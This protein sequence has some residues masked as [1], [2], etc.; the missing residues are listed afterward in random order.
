MAELENTF[1]WSYSAASDFEV[2]RRR[3]YWSKYGKWGG[4]SPQASPEQRKAYQLDKMDNLYS[5]LG[6]AVDLNPFTVIVAILIG[7][8]LLGL[9]GVVIAIPTAA[10]LKVI[11]QYYYSKDERV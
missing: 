8:T 9:L 7:G 11:I 2:C 4:W 6:Q 1:S 5:L 10:A 3:R